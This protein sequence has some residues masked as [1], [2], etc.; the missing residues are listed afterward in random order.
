[1]TFRVIDLYGDFGLGLSAS[2]VPETDYSAWGSGTT[3]ARGDR[4]IAT[5]TH[6]IYE[7]ARSGN[8]AKNPTLATNRYNPESN[9]TG[10]WIDVGATNRWR[11]FDQRLY[12]QATR[13]TSAQWTNLLGQTIDA[14]AV[15]GLGG[16]ASSVQCEVLVS[17]SPVSSST[18]SLAAT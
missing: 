5:T 2:T 10:W 8:L 7:S 9:P 3:Y 13:A 12:D 15:L 14:V 6:R 11:V 16:G 1:M 4:V 17:G 18:I